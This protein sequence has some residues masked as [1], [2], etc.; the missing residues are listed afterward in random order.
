ME[1]YSR[2][3]IEQYCR[4]HGNT[5]KAKKLQRLVSH[6]YD[7]AYTGTDV[8]ALWLEGAI[9]REKNP[10]LKEAMQDLDDYLFGW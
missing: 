10:E 4:E 9:R 6:S 8:E 3:T 5:Q 2:I 1:E 7:P